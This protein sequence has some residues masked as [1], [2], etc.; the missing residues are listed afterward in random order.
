MVLGAT[1]RLSC[2]IT[3]MIV[4]SSSFRGNPQFLG[5]SPSPVFTARHGP[6][7]PATE[8]YPDR[9]RCL[10]SNN[11]D[12]SSALAIL[13]CTS[14]LL[15]SPFLS[16]NRWCKLGNVCVLRPSTFLP[17]K[18]GLSGIG[19][20]PLETWDEWRHSLATYSKPKQIY[21]TAPN[22]TSSGDEI[23][24]IFKACKFT[25]RI[26]SYMQAVTE[27]LF[28]VLGAIKDLEKIG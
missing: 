11:V 26:I 19:W 6:N 3:L 20:N 25:K 1:D 13:R 15:F 4:L 24:S 18:I 8:L 21:N 10:K 14:L 22:D 5:Y 23:S 12:L 7:F 17:S 27:T 2:I 9:I 28:G 16:L